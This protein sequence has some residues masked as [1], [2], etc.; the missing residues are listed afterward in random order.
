MF[1]GFI[2]TLFDL[3]RDVLPSRED[4]PR[5]WLIKMSVVLGAI[6]VFG[7][8]SY[9]I[10]VN[11][12][13]GEKY[14]VRL[15]EREK[16]LTHV[17]YV[18]L[19]SK[20]WQKLASLRGDYPDVKAVI[21]VIIYDRSTGNMILTPQYKNAGNLIW[22]WSLPLDKLDTL[23]PFEK[24]LDTILEALVKSMDERGCVSSKIPPE[25]LAYF[26]KGVAK[27]DFNHAVACPMFSSYEPGKQRFIV[28]YT[29][30]FYNSPD[31]KDNNFI[32]AAVRSVTTEF[33]DSYSFLKPYIFY[34]Y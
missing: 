12:T 22:S 25:L 18:E 20:N 9:F 3:V 24:G 6:G 14:N 19:A 31:G 16:P 23:R 10:L 21:V 1:L 27:F 11:T 32:E 4:T 2:Q 28:G 8:A 5:V 30:A 29:V 33:G 34:F 7:T 26:R 15:L 17:E 13:L